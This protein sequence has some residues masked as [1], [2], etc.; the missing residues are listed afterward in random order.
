MNPFEIT[1]PLIGPGSQPKEEDGAELTYLSMPKAMRTYDAPG[2]P[3]AEEI[4]ACPAGLRL[5]ERLL[6]DLRCHRVCDPSRVLD[7]LSLP[8]ADR[9]LVTQALG[10]GEVSILFA[11]DAVLRVQETRLAGVWR[12]QTCGELG[13]ILR[14]EIEVAEIPGLARETA[15]REAVAQTLTDEQ[16]PEGALTAR[17][18]LAEL[19]AKVA[20]WCPGDPPHVVNLTL[21]PHWEQDLAY[22]DRQLALGPITILSRG[23]G[24]CRITAT[25]LRHCWWVQH[26]NSD[27][28]L[29]LNT[30][31]VVDV[32]AAALAAQEDLEDSAA[33]LVE[34]LDAVR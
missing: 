10:E 27:D 23:Y 11:A 14:D 19:N 16:P 30:L 3:E 25:G 26:F 32:P 2:L 8:E 20:D 22:L 29:I 31:E 18:V 34:I 12:V 1:S 24:N 5:L 17:S 6:E 28:K 21:L 15:F 13:R 4:H 9:L 7:L 33:R